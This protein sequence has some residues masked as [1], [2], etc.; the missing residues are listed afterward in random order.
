MF[1]TI[2]KREFIEGIQ[3]IIRF[4]QHGATSLPVL[5]CVL[6]IA[7][8]D[9]IKFRANNLEIAADFKISGKINTNGVVAIP[10]GI[11]QQIISTLNNNGVITLEQTGDTVIITTDHIKSTIKTISQEDFPN[12]PAIQNKET[13]SID[14]KILT[15]A[16]D[17]TIS[18]A[19]TSNIR[20]ELASIFFTLT[21]NSMTVVATDSFRLVEKTI[22][23]S[24]SIKQDISFLVP[25]KNI[26]EILKTIPQSTKIHIYIDEHQLVIKWDE[27]IITSRLTGGTYPDYKQIIPKQTTKKAVV[28]RKDF[29]ALLKHTSIFSDSFQKTTLMFNPKEKT[30]S[31]SSHNNDTGSSTGSV[32]A[33]VSGDPI[34]LSFNYRYLQAPISLTQAENLSL[35]A[36]NIGQPLIVRSVGDNSFLY[37]VMPMN[38]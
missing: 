26:S 22:P 3:K 16:V 13:L 36:N 15:S 24:L 32:P 18:C 8:D 5:S 28:L 17:A 37:L 31:L 20:P 19:S 29:D 14:S 6:I 10:A 25:A 33:E 27:N 11:L 4:T 23:V 38:Q 7:G 12:I 35:H 1:I 34:E 2:E 9:G 30:V 21:V